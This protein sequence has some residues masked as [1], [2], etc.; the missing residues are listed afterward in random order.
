MTKI[1]KLF[2]F[3]G[4]EYEGT[5]PSFDDVVDKVNEIIDVINRRGKK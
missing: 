4:G 5:S 1:S 2:I 3:K